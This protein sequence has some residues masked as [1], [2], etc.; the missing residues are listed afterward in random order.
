VSEAKPNGTTFARVL[1]IASLS[2][3]Y[4]L[5][6]SFFRGRMGRCWGFVVR[7][8]APEEARATTGR[9]YENLV[10]HAM[11]HEKRFPQAMLRR[12]YGERASTG[13]PYAGVLQGRYFAARSQGFVGATCGRPKSPQAMRWRKKIPLERISPGIIF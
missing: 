13:R 11:R 3:S 6:R 12:E 4:A 5:G 10:L 9:P 7:R 2:P 8:F 1:G